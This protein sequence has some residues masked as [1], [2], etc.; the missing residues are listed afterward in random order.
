MS[1]THIPSYYLLPLFLC[2]V[3]WSQTNSCL[4]HQSILAYDR[5]PNPT[6]AIFRSALSSGT[7]LDLESK[8]CCWCLSSLLLPHTI[9]SLGFWAG[10]PPYFSRDDLS[11][12]LHYT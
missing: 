11:L 12:E 8:V 7:R 2:A 6:L 1:V 4:M 9:V 10:I 5:P 3:R